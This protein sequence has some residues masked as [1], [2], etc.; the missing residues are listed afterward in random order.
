MWLTWTWGVVEAAAIV[1]SAVAV[2]G[3]GRGGDPSGGPGGVRADGLPRLVAR[4][5]TP[6]PSPPP[7]AQTVVLDANESP[8]DKLVLLFALTNALDLA[9]L[10]KVR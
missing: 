2:G 6:S 3:R 10:A 7:P 8:L 1:G 5:V 9:H 4:V